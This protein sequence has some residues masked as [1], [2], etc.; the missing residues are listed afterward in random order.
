MRH[1]FFFSQPWARQISSCLIGLVKVT[2]V[3]FEIKCSTAKEGNA[4]S[5]KRTASS[6]PS[7]QAAT[8]GNTTAIDLM[9]I[10]IM[11]ETD[12]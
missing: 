3:Y 8:F 12:N 11:Q 2:G 5:E 7:P 9:A 10:R 1:L 4:V 6:Q